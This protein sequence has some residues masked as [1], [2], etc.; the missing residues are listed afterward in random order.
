MAQAKN[1]PCV[2]DFKFMSMDLTWSIEGETQLVRRLEKIT[3]STKE[4]TPAFQQA[5]DYL[6]R[7]FSQDVFASNGGAIGET[8]APLKPKYLAQKV[9]QGYPADILVRTGAMKNAFMSLVKSDS[10]TIWNGM[11]YFKYHQSKEPRS[12]LP[13]RVMMKL[14]NNQ[15]E[16]VVKIFHTYW[17]NQM[18][19]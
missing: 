14:G 10:A 5:S 6:K 18:K 4:A 15:K 16:F 7:V 1:L 8:W 11:Q 17:Y 3:A 12:K 19:A 2:K 13:R 9:S